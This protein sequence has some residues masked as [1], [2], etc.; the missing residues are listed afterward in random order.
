MDDSRITELFFER[1]EQAIVELSKKYGALCK[2][3]AE[4][5]LK[6]PQDAEECVNDAYHAVWDNIPPERPDPLAGYVCK[7]V[8]NLALKKYHANTAE[9]RNST[10]DVSLDELADCFPAFSNV[11]E[12]AAVREMTQAINSFLGTLS[13]T[14]R[15]MFVK[16]YWQAESIENLAA[17][18]QT[19]KHYISVRLSRIRKELKKY[20]LKEGLLT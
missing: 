16:R 4:N 1:S 7:V 6:N 15:V 2:R 13:Q 19:S 9:K 8:R 14:D 10:Y 20:M 11:E 18:F 3:V 5:I 17:L 12:E